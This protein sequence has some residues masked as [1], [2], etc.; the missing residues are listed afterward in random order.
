MSTRK[1]QGPNDILVLLV[2]GRGHVVN[3]Q[4]LTV[5]VGN[6]ELKDETSIF[7]LKK[8]VGRIPNEMNSRR[9]SLTSGIGHLALHTQPSQ[10]QWTD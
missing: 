10:N 6:F 2:R 4:R 7:M 3:W 5:C 1:V 9:P 8:I